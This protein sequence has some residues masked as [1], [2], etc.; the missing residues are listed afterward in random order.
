MRSAG[1]CSK[2]FLPQSLERGTLEGE[3]MSI[4]LEVCVRLQKSEAGLNIKLPSHMHPPNILIKPTENSIGDP[5]SLPIMASRPLTLSFSRSSQR[6]Y[7]RRIDCLQ[8][9][10]PKAT[11]NASPILLGS[12][13]NYNVRGISMQ[14][15][16]KISKFNWQ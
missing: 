12:C 14:S 11:V 15:P 10:T 6:A 4:V 13:Q 3:E 2:P 7:A 5:A 8:F 1:E 9:T 16:R